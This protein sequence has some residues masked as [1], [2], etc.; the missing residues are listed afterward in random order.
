MNATYGHLDFYQNGSYAASTNADSSINSE[1][2]MHLINTKDFIE[3]VFKD[4]YQ[5]IRP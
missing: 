1:L 5:R 3:V 2:H 4:L